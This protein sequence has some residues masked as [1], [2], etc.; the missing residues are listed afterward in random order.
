MVCPEGRGQ[1]DR[2][3]DGKAG[4]P[5][6]TSSG[7]FYSYE[8]DAEAPSGL[9]VLS[10]SYNSLDTGADEIAGTGRASSFG[11]GWSSLLDTTTQRVNVPSEG[12]LLRMRLPDGRRYTASGGVFSGSEL[13]WDPPSSLLLDRV[14]REESSSGSG[15]KQYHWVFTSGETWSFDS[16]GRLV[17]VSDPHG[18]DLSIARG[19]NG[20]ATRVVFTEG[21]SAGW[22]VDVVD[23]NGDRYVDVLAGPYD[24]SL[25]S[26]PSDAVKRA[27]SYSGGFLQFA[28]EPYTG[29]TAPGVGTH[30][31]FAGTTRLE[32]VER[33]HT[34]TRRD[35]VVDNDYD[36]V[37]RVIQ[38]TYPSGEVDTFN[39]AATSTEM[40]T[41]VAHI[42]G[43][44]S[45]TL[46]YRHDLTGRLLEI[47]DPYSETTTRAWDR[48]LP[49]SMR[50]RR[51]GETAASYDADG[52]P[53]EVHLPDPVTAGAQAGVVSMTYC[54]AGDPRPVDV[55]DAAGVVTRYWW[56]TGGSPTPC[57]AGRTVPVKVTQAFGTGAAWDTTYTSTD[58]LVDRVTVDP[59]G[60][61]LVSDYFWDASKRLM[62][63]SVD[64]PAGPSSAGRV[65]YYGYDGSGRVRV[66]RDPGG[67]ETW[68]V[69]NAAGQVTS[70]VGPVTVSRS[71]G[72]TSCSFPTSP[73]SGPTQSWAYNADGSIASYTDALNKVTT[74]ESVYTS[75]G[76]RIETV[77]PPTHGNS[78]SNWSSLT[79]TVTVSTYDGFDR[80][81]SVAVGDPSIPGSVA[82]TT[83]TY[84]PLGRVAASSETVGAGK[85]NLVRSFAYDADG[86]QTVEAYGSNPSLTDNALWVR[87]YDLRGRLVDEKGPTGDSTA[88]AA[89]SGT[90]PV[91]VR[92]HRTWDYD[93]ADRLLA[94]T[95][96]DG[97]E[98]QTTFYR[99]DA[100]S[101]VRYV[102]E[103]RDGDGVVPPLS[104]A[105]TDPGDGVVESIYTGSGLLHQ[106]VDSPVDL[107][108]YDWAGGNQA[109]KRPTTFTYDGAAQATA[110]EAPN[111]DTTTYA[112]TATGLVQRE[113]LEGGYYTDYGYDAAGRTTRVRNPSPTGSGTVDVITAH[114][115]RGDVTSV[116]NPHVTG[117]SSPPSV[118][119]GYYDDGSMFYSV[120][121]L[122]GWDN[123][124]IYAYDSRGNRTERLSTT[125]AS[126]SSTTHT[127]TDT[128]A[129]DLA[130]RV[131]LER[132][133]G[134]PVGTAY[135]YDDF[136]GRPQLTVWP[137]GRIK[138]SSWWNNGAPKATGWN[139]PASGSIPSEVVVRC[140]WYDTAG[141]TTHTLG[142]LNPS[143]TCAS[144]TPITR[145]WTA[146][147]DLASITYPDN[148][149]TPAGVD[150]DLRF[151]WDLNG[152]PRT[153][154]FDD[155]SVH[156]TT[157]DRNGRLT[158]TSKTGLAAG[159]IAAYTY[160][161]NGNVT[162]ETVSAGQTT[163][164]WTYPANGSPHPSSYV[165]ASPGAN[166][167]T[168]LTWNA[169]GDLATETTAGAT[170]TYAYD[171]ARQLLSRNDTAGTDYSYSYGPRGL[172]LTQT[173][174]TTT[175]TYTYNDRAQVVAASA[176]WIYSTYTYNA[177]GQRTNWNLS[178]ILDADYVYDPR[179]YTQHVDLDLN[180]AYG[181]DSSETRT[182]DALGNLTRHQRT[183]GGSSSGDTT[184]VDDPT[185]PA[186]Q[187]AITRTS[188]ANQST[189][190]YGLD[191]VG[192]Q[193]NNSSTP[194]NLAFDHQHSALANTAAPNLPLSYDPYGTP[195][196]QR[197]AQ[198]GYRTE[199]HY[200]YLVYLRNRDYDPVLGAFTTPDPL[201]GLTANVTETN[202]YHYANNN[203]TNQADPT[204]LS[205]T[206]DDA[207]SGAGG[208][209]AGYACPVAG[210]AVATTEGGGNG[211]ALTVICSVLAGSAAILITAGT[212]LSSDQRE[213]PRTEPP[214]T[215]EPSEPR[216]RPDPRQRPRPGPDQ[217]PPIPAEPS[218]GPPDCSALEETVGAHGRLPAA[219]GC[220]R[221]HIIQD[222][223][224][225]GRYEEADRPYS[226]YSAPAII[227]SK[228]RHLLASEVQRQSTLCSGTFQEERKVA[229]RALIAA[230]V[231]PFAFAMAKEQVMSY[232]VYELHWNDATETTVPSNRFNCK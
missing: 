202:P 126:S 166:R 108:S 11:R 172:R 124:V 4:E 153:T 5:V 49:T 106:H 86:N 230:G 157:H 9:G 119:F 192:H 105:P 146:S 23:T 209:S 95:V 121:Q 136:R 180:P 71:C 134:D 69:R 122:G 51:G 216:H 22:A 12:P 155:G 100:A 191:L 137:S 228:P 149:N 68:W 35:L 13:D 25:S 225:K 20:L 107:T 165:Q 226:S 217:P 112:Y 96:G 1:G 189:A 89:V 43:T 131:T 73:P 17:S 59:G 194:V 110:V 115:A 179:G 229:D 135:G 76:G 81:V 178:S 183:S 79:R 154:T 98:R 114:N 40:T 144:G 150:E 42:A 82:T 54:A 88:P 133:A 211:A 224:A 219:P 83:Y 199:T 8:V 31:D 80:L 99:Y 212:T 92:G 15:S 78:A 39:Y 55:T 91:A 58:G 16:A 94:E 118:G 188:P 223:A 167:T 171:A 52:R 148:V 46:T 24:A 63:A 220:E 7:N 163:R 128:W 151:T 195:D 60:D 120:N 116:T 74:Y 48:D 197:P 156:A 193:H 208:P 205:P 64:Y 141:N 102:I 30:Y 206:D 129:Y 27:F 221:H 158:G 65:T 101:R 143:S 176:P 182:Y 164:T 70:Q 213:V 204:G 75:G 175:T 10:R 210:A 168:A 127:V 84:D 85:P 186:D 57:D 21:T 123:V 14:Y 203:P 181:T 184:Y 44:A 162:T 130:D 190:N 6:S 177:D 33:D 231:K 201:L 207:S 173:A 147:G 36:T 72:A 97:A 28:S 185:R 161:D 138:L 111:G 34:G 19:S 109:L 117:A 53:E 104:G 170:R 77:T 26:A 139:R 232:F 56:T 145:T 38:Q 32:K 159:P 41:T 90:A 47:V 103:D 29:T 67:A 196:T 169:A 125:K 152:L 18:P 222:A 87:T 160:D 198:L 37:G 45:E 200:S 62:T 2:K 3:S 187:P 215:S 214:P 50:Q 132:P 61:A 113:T 174:D 227:L 218:T 93:D 66:Q 142:Q 140:D